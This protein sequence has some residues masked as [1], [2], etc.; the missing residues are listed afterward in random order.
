M[1][2]N[3]FCRE[4]AW[5]WETS[6]PLS[7]CDSAKGCV[8]QG[9]WTCVKGPRLFISGTG[10]QRENDWKG[11]SLLLSILWCIAVLT[12]LLVFLSVLGWEATSG[13][14]G[15]NVSLS[16]LPSLCLSFA[17][18]EGES[19]YVSPGEV[20]SNCICQGFHSSCH[21][22]PNSRSLSFSLFRNARAVFC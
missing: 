14:W 20:A 22:G 11:K 10:C 1:T 9:Q 8:F 6:K 7:P 21:G 5:W 3:V 15:L 13:R 2:R 17:L 16:L 4:F 19:L 12:E 18:S